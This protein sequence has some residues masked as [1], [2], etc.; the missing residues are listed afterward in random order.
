MLVSP[1]A[2]LA[3]PWA[4]DEAARPCQLPEGGGLVAMALTVSSSTDCASTDWCVTEE[5]KDESSSCEGLNIWVSAAA[6]WAEAWPP[7][8]PACA[9]QWPAGWW[10]SGGG[11]VA[12]ALTVS[13]STDCASTDWCVTEEEE[14]ESSSC[15]GLNIWVSAAAL[16][17]EAWPP[18]FPACACQWPA[19]WWVSGGG[20]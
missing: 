7:A 19:G 11:L 18:A 8:F 10:V 17:A 16:W 4:S 3:A 6:L 2:A 13:P 12:M 5:E 15:E 20:L 14:D 1:C 9:C